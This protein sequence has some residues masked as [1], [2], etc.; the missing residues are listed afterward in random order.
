[1]KRPEGDGTWSICTARTMKQ[2]VPVAM[3][4]AS[5]SGQPAAAFPPRPTSV[6]SQTN[7]NSLRLSIHCCRRDPMS[8]TSSVILKTRTAFSIFS[9]SI[10]R[11]RVLSDGK[12]KLDRIFGASFA[13]AR[14]SLRQEHVQAAYSPQRQQGSR[15]APYRMRDREVSDL[16][17]SLSEEPRRSHKFLH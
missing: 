12:N 3:S 2:A 1:M 6:S 15:V 5:S 4:L 16:A 8:V 9:I 7:M 13:P 17:I 14:L 10:P 11:E